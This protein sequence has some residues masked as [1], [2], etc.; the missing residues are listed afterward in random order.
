MWKKLWSGRG[1]AMH[2]WLFTMQRRVRGGLQ[3][4]LFKNSWDACMMPLISPI[5]AV[6]THIF[7][8]SYCYT[9]WSAII[10]ISLLSVRPSVCD[11]VH[12]GSQ[13]WCT[14]L[15]LTPACSYS[16]QVP[17]H[18]FWHFCCRMYRL[19]T[20]WTTKKPSARATNL[21]PNRQV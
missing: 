12:C 2:A 7:S 1:R 20:K 19:A 16:I 13:G 15:K 8:R 9:V 5:F 3:F 10:G 11:A 21:S 18:P 6:M 14:R 4:C 17:I